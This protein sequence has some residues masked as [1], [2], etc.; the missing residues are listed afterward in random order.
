VDVF[1]DCTVNTPAGRVDVTASGQTIALTASKASSFWRLMDTA[2]IGRAR[3]GGLLRR[4]VA[5]LAIGDLTL[6]VRSGR[7]EI[8]RIEPGRRGGLLSRTLGL[9]GVRLR[10]AGLLLSL[11][12]NR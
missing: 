2:Q 12:T 5:G 9:P 3:R 10:P 8:A 6:S 4:V 11:L 7:R 1:A